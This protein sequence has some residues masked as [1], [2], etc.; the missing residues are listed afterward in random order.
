MMLAPWHHLLH[1]PACTMEPKT[2]HELW[3]GLCHGTNA[4][5]MVH[6]CQMLAV[7]TLVMCMPVLQRGSVTVTH[8][9]VR[10]ICLQG[11]TYCCNS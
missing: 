7:K 1:K 2:N 10:L 11:A 8:V 6:V 4:C 3:H 9:Y 5:S